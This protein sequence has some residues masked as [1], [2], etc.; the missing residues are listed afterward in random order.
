MAKGVKLGTA[1]PVVRFGGKVTLVT[2]STVSKDGTILLKMP[3]LF[4]IARQK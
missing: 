3:R 1:K 4:F 2:F